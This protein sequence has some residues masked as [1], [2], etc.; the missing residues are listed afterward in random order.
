MRLIDADELLQSGFFGNETIPERILFIGDVESM[1]TIDPIQ[2]GKWVPEI[3]IRP[4]TKK[5]AET[6]RVLCSECGFGTPIEF[7]YCPRCGAKMDEVK[8]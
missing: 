4:I 1:P 3:G 8:D 6:G 5:P 2:R 7:N